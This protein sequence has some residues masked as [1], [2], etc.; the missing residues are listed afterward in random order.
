MKSQLELNLATPVK[1]NR[2]CFYKY[3]EN[4]RK[5]KENHHPLLGL[6]GNI[7]NDEEEAEILNDLFASLFNSKDNQPLKLVGRDKKQSRPAAVWN[8]VVN[9]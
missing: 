6:A 8:K 2:K 1:D 9:D 7:T 3:I 5:T 4:R